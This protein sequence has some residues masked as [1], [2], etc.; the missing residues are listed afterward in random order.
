MLLGGRWGGIFLLQA[1][2]NLGSIL[3]AAGTLVPDW[4]LQHG[5]V[6]IITRSRLFDRLLIILVLSRIFLT[7]NNCCLNCGNIGVSFFHC[8]SI[9]LL[10]AVDFGGFLILWG[11]LRR[12]LRLPHLCELALHVLS[13]APQ[14]ECAFRVAKAHEAGLVGW[15]LEDH[16]E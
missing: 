5:R 9:L 2:L 6:V 15:L 4:L 1:D 12:L 16:F 7:L 14:E 11:P 10:N 8:Q 3:G 13:N